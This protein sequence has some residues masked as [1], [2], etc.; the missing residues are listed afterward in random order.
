DAERL[1]RALL[2]LLS[3][4]HKYG[5]EGG[6]IELGLQARDDAI[7]FR[8]ADNG[9]GIA[10]HDQ[11]RIFERFFRPDEAHSR[12]QPGTGLG[13]PIAQAMVEMHGGRLW[14]ESAPG[15]G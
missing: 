6:S 12:R 5:R 3:N 14:V 1:E 15:A 7:V 8:V 9:P 4:A 10:E 11:R 2:N 13:L